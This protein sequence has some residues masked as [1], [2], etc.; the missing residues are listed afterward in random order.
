MH[1]VDLDPAFGERTWAQ[2]ESALGEIFQRRESGL[3]YEEL[4]R[5]AYNMV[6]HKHGDRLY[7][8]F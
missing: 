2:L 6:L 3:S 1:K 7:S 8:G 4:Y 5:G